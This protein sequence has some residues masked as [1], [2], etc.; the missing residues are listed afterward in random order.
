MCVWVSSVHSQNFTAF[1]HSS[2]RDTRSLKYLSTWIFHGAPLH[3]LSSILR[4]HQVACHSFQTF[5]HLHILYYRCMMTFT[6]QT[7][8]GGSAGFVSGEGGEVLQLGLFP[9]GCAVT[10]STLLHWALHWFHSD[11]L[12]SV[13]TNLIS[14]TLSTLCLIRSAPRLSALKRIS[15]VLKEH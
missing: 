4:S 14:A 3:R 6:G 7:C 5:T 13:I 9:P 15:V 1:Q 12:K 10:W 11:G 8:L 2:S